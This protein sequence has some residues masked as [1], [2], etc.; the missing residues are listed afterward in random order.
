MVEKRSV[1][2]P[3][4]H[5][6]LHVI[7]AVLLNLGIV[8][9]AVY[10]LFH[11]LEYY[12]PHTF[13]YPNIPWLPFAIPVLFILSVL[14]FDLLW[15]DGAFKKYRFKKQRMWL[16][17]LCD[18]I[19]FAA[20][21][22]T[23]YLKTCT[24]PLTEPNTIEEYM[25]PTPGSADVPTPVPSAP[26][27]EGTEV[28]ASSPNT[29]PSS[30]ESVETA[31][32]S[33]SGAPIEA[34]G[35]GLLKGA[36]ADKF[37]DPPIEQCFDVT[38]VVETLADG[39]EK[40]LIYTY[41][42]RNAAVEI[43]HYQRG[44]LEYQFAD[45]YI[46]DIDCFSTVYS[47]VY[48]KNVK[49]QEYAAR[50]NAI[51]AVNGDNFNSGKIND[52]LVIRNGAQLYPGSGSRPTSYTRDVCVLYHDGTIRVY[53]CVL[54]RINYDEILSNYPLQV[55]YFGP[56]LLNDDGT[57]RTK[58]NSV[59]T[60]A[61]PRTVLGYFEPGHYGLVVVLGKREMIDYQ[62]KNLGNG[63]SSGL[64]MSD[65]SELCVQLG[66]KAAYNLDGGGSSGMVWNK[67]VF[68]HNDRSHADVLAVTDP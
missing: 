66:F 9:S 56:K 58:F 52:G 57:S 34:D 6:A 60:K 25:L 5:R 46:N 65:L 63:K 48:R 30:N 18:L 45:V 37:S 38:N 8:F 27:P 23:L 42:G 67:T 28:P 19:L 33:P 7:A 61:N 13:I 29:L 14:L 59:L 68:G 55:F 10:I 24:N 26:Q 43:Y 2:S 41:H 51:V 22:M 20:I 49:T 64:T 21:S 15:I 4:A 12:N 17:I 36:Y 44:K 16:V 31:F 53:D 32:A 3:K 62:G 1:L 11:L 47:T 39:T 35:R 54:D 40:A 50:I